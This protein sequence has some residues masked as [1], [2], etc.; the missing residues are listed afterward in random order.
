MVTKIVTSNF[1][2]S[3]TNFM[4]LNI[5][6]FFLILDSARQLYTIKNWNKLSSTE[7]KDKVTLHLAKL[8]TENVSSNE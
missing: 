6:Y 5:I 2:S 7:I 3:L 1:F 8:V 4:L